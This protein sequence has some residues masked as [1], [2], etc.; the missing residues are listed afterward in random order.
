MSENTD[1]E[2]LVNAPVRAEPEQEQGARHASTK[3]SAPA[4]GGFSVTAPTARTKITAPR[5]PAISMGGETTQFQVPLELLVMA[6]NKEKDRARSVAVTPVVPKPRADE[7]PPSAELSHLPAPQALEGEPD[8]GIEL[9]EPEG[10][11][12]ALAAEPEVAHEV[13]DAIA[14]ATSAHSS[15]AAPAVAESGALAAAPEAVAAVVPEAEPASGASART[16][17]LLA[18]AYVGACYLAAQLMHWL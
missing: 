4:A 18:V 17:V 3:P 5:G 7:G 16:W 13:G 9:P 11:A 8:P 14:A 15:D 1:V 6:R 12:D 2:G 10:D